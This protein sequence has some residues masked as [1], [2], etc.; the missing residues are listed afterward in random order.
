MMNLSTFRTIFRAELQN[1]FENQE[2]ETFFYWLCEKYLHINK[3]DLVFNL[4]YKLTSEEQL[5]FDDSLSLLKQNTPIQYVLGETSFYGL[6]FLVNKEV[7]IPRPETEELVS[8][9]IE[10]FKDKPA[11]IFDVCTGSGCI[12]ITLGKFLTSATIDACDVSKNAIKTAQTNALLNK[13][14]VCF[15]VR[16]VLKTN[17]LSKKWDA[18]VSNPP[19]VT[20]DEKKFMKPN[21]LDFE[22][23]LALFVDNK[24]PLLFYEKIAA[25]AME[26][27]TPNGK[28]YFEI[29]EAFGDEVIT[30]LK[31]VGY[32][33][34]ILKKDFYGKNRMIRATK[35]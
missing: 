8:W 23:H 28:L 10:D 34:I 26:Y 1:Q 4:D 17:R 2:I 22:P 29:N 24:S 32:Q 15:E 13:V 31:S 30:L 5:L 3:V 18:W 20:E 7:L 35:I 33:D 12:A 14:D 11:S 16:N 27:L 25:L 21:V 9:V 19:Y 6:D